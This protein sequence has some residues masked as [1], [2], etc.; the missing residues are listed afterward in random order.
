[1]RSTGN[2]A[3]EVVAQFQQSLSQIQIKQINNNNVVLCCNPLLYFA[4]FGC[5]LQNANLWFS[6]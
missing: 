1:M 3:V 4:Q 6:N 2:M 5:I